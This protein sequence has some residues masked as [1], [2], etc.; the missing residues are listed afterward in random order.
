MVLMQKEIRDPWENYEILNSTVN[1][2][3]KLFDVN[4]TNMSV[5]LSIQKLQ[6]Q[7]CWNRIHSISIS[8]FYLDDPSLSDVTYLK[9]GD[10]RY[11]FSFSYTYILHFTLKY[12]EECI[13]VCHFKFDS[14]L[15][16]IR[17]LIL[18][19]FVV[20][21]SRM[22]MIFEWRRWWRFQVRKVSC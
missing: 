4:S 14:W 19:R 2:T 6:K 22:W 16:G 9:D 20:C 8:E 12:K 21:S 17:L 3:S 15:C 11:T 7:K 1:R 10:F 5:Y 18:L 13:F